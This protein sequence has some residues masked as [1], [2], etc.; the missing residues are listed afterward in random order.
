[1]SNPTT[2]SEAFSSARATEARF[3]EDALSKRL[4]RGTVSEYKNEFEML[5]SQVTG[6]FESLF[7]TIYIFGLKPALQIE[8]LMSRLIILGEAFSLACI[9]EARFEAIAHEGK[10]TAEKEQNIKETSDI[11]TSLQSEVV[12]LKAK[13]SLDA[14]EEIK[15]DHTLVHEL[16][17]Q[18]EKL[19]MKLQLKNNFREV[20][21]T[22]SKDLE[23]TM[24]DLNPA[25][26]DLQKVA[27]DRKKK[28]YKTKHAL[29]IVDEEFKKVKSEATTKIRKLAKVYGAWLPPFI[30]LM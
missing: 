10:A 17:K 30:S 19:P 3:V 20:L 28:H 29:N 25:L 27:V 7:T 12:S 14:N 15:E 5:I 6:K 22:T 1:M 18:E 24:L 21:E 13:G 4:Q 23:K 8:L 2:L 11:N 26:H 9:I 16:R